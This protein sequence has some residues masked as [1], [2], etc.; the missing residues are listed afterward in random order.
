MALQ[1]AMG[2]TVIF[3]CDFEYQGPAITSSIRCSIGSHPGFFDE[4]VY[5][6]QPISLGPEMVWKAYRVS[7]GV[8]IKSPL[9]EGETFWAQ[10]KIP[11]AAIPNLFVE[12]PDAITIVGL[13]ASDFRN[14]SVSFR[15]G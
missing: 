13:P 12:I 14:L 8:M 15:K 2:D 9:W 7:V 4:K 1:V 11:N 6:A 10:V 3:D 5:T